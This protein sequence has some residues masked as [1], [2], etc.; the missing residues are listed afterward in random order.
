[1]KGLSE[2]H[3]LLEGDGRK[4]GHAVEGLVKL[5]HLPGLLLDELLELQGLQAGQGAGPGGRLAI[6]VRQGPGVRGSGVGIVQL[7]GM[8]QEQ[9]SHVVDCTMCS[10]ADHDGYIWVGLC[11]FQWGLEHVYQLVC[12]R[13]PRVKVVLEE[14]AGGG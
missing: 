2:P 6:G 9:A 4:L 14:V 10:W 1:M 11:T 7:H 13:S 8:E 3:G 5:Q 12:H